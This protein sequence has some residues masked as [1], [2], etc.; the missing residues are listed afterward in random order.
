MIFH[1]PVTRASDS[2]FNKAKVKDFS[3]PAE[4]APPERHNLL[5]NYQAI[6]LTVMNDLELI[7]VRI[8]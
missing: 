3:K 4:P 1:F 6:L 5:H 2:Q 7:E 8:N